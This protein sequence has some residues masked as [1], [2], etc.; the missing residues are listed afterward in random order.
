MS[1]PATARSGPGVARVQLALIGAVV[2]VAGAADRVAPPAHAEGL[3]ILSPIV[4]SVGDQRRVAEGS[5]V[6]LRVIRPKLEIARDKASGPVVGLSISGDGNLLFALLEDGDGRVWD[7]HEGGQLGGAVSEHAVAGA[8]VGTGSDTEI[9]IAHRDGLL[10]ATRPGDGTRRIAATGAPLGPRPSPVLSAGG[11]A[12]A[13]PAPDGG[14]TLMRDGRKEHLADAAV[15]FA[16]MLSA[17][18]TRTAYSL[19]WGSLVAAHPFAVDRAP[20][21]L[22]GCSDDAGVTAGAFMP[23]GETLVLGDRAGNVCVGPF[24]ERSASVRFRLSDRAHDRPVQAV[25]VDRGGRQFA[26][27]D[28]G[29]R[30]QVWSVSPRFRPVSA[31]DLAAASPAAAVAIDAAR[32]WVLVGEAAGTIGIYDYAG[33][34]DPRRIASLLC[35]DDGGWAVVDSEGRFDG[36]MEGVDAL[37]WAG[38]TAADTLPV[39]AFSE[40]WFEPGLLGKLD[41]EAPRFLN[42]EAASLTEDG[43][44]PPPRVSID[45]V[46]A[47]AVDGDGWL[48]VTVRFEDPE[49][50]P[51]AV[52]HVRLYH[53]GKLVPQDRMRAAPGQTTFEYPVRLLPGENT[54]HA[55]GVS[56]LGI[57]GRPSAPVMA[58]GPAPD[59]ERSRMQV[60]SI[61]IN[62]YVR[63]TWELS[64]GRNDARAVAETLG[65]GGD[66]LFRDIRT[67][68]LLDADATATAIKG[69]IA[70]DSPSAGDVLV[71]YFSGH[72][73][74]LPEGGGWEWYL[75]PF[76]EA[77]DVAGDVT[78]SMVRQHGVSS[79]DL[80]RVLTETP[81]SRVFL[82]LDSCRSGAVADAMGRGM[83][84]E[85]VGQKALR[86]IARVGGIHVLAA[87][88]GDED[89]VELV[90]R[91]HGALTYLLLEGMRGK[92][93]GNSDGEI[94]V[95]EI[96]GYATREMPLLARRLVAETISQLPVGYSRGAD[97]ALVGM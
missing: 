96:V 6:S 57:E 36:P 35:T 21:A 75:L 70:W 83:F 87:S 94:S 38:D 54:F 39:D 5:R 18:G 58:A 27:L 97:F 14:W 61:G 20:V 52:P 25:A 3:R 45:P 15:T 17:D 73:V 9:I 31:F 41:D 95:R 23:D 33:G 46:D 28:V 22:P 47:R 81:A 51:E 93:D 37:F 53:N 13:F 8:A 26:T 85:A 4:R 76:T 2:V 80:M 24:P 90:S 92:A 40:N 67:L 16:P 7:L 56:A 82:I 34:R 63:P 48:L 1:P 77:W 43:Y 71:V 32:H 62:D 79:R 88:R 60:V 30:V 72:G 68:T 78:A 10:T 11:G 66:R 55:V 64:Y 12:V 86:R 19:P 89:A 84:D 50:P 65:V 44:V 29:G 49:H 69:R 59:R 42:E 91:P 74:A